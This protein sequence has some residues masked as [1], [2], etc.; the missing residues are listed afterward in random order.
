[1]EDLTNKTNTELVME[2]KRLVLEHEALKNKLLQE[3]DKLVELEKQF[4]KIN[5][6]LVSR[7][8]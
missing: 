5:N 2:A 1:M 3:Y 7:N 4:K 8:V 6:I